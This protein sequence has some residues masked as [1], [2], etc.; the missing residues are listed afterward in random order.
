MT[1][2]LHSRERCLYYSSAGLGA[3][4]RKR[5]AYAVPLERVDHSHLDPQPKTKHS[6][7]VAKID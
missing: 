5:R 7:F 1:H 3:N 6:T 2:R 4:V